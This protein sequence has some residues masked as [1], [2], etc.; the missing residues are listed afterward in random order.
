M[1]QNHRD[2]VNMLVVI[3]FQKRAQELAPMRSTVATN[4]GEICKQRYDAV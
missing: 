1:F 2:L 3:V 4:P